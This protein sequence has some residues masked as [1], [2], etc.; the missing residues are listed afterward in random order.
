MSTATKRPLKIGLLLPDTEGQMNGE[1]PRWSD[2]AALARRAEEI[3]FDSVW[4]TDHFIQRNQPGDRGPWECW[5]LLSALAVATS[6]VEIGPLV[7]CTGFRN[8]AMLAKMADTVEEISNGRLIL[9]LGAGWNKAEYDAFGYPFDHRF[10]RFEEALAIITGLLRAGQADFDGTYYRASE[11]VLRPRGPRPDGPPILIGTNG[12]RMLEL[13][14]RH[15][16]HW[17]T[18]FSPYKNRVD[19]LI[20]MLREVDAACE[21]VGRDPNTLERS[22]AVKIATLPHAPSTMSVAP[23]DGTPEQIADGLRAF[24]AAGLDHV[25]L[26]IEPA[27]LDGLEAFIPVLEL[28][29]RG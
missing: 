28:L 7:L 23:L 9:G 26:W 14:A 2:I 11:A 15:A 21:A 16:D 27:T 24:T 19:Q 17:N 12:K 22:A 25:Q 3:G 20:P 6:R 1:S 4:V 13:T 18:W 8:P 10:D 29:D 5:S